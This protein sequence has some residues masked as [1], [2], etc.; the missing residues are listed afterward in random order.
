MLE[1][2]AAGERLLR[3]GYAGDTYNTAVYIRRVAVELGLDLDVGYL[4]GLGGDD[5]SAQMRA[6]W[7]EEGIADRSLTIPGRLPGLYAVTT[8]AT[9]ERRFSY[10][11]EQSAASA[12][13]AGSDWC[14]QLGADLVHLSGITLQLVAPEARGTLRDRLLELRAGGTLVSFD[15]NYRAAG[16]PSPAA[17][18]EA[19]AELAGACDIVFASDGDERLLHGPGSPAEHIGR[20]AAGTG[21]EVI[22]RSGAGGAYVSSGGAPAVHVAAVPV[23]RVVDTTGAGDAFGG[24]YLAARLAGEPPPRAAAFG[25]AVAGQVI[26]HPGA[27]T[28]QDIRLLGRVDAAI[29]AIGT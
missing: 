28:A 6:A 12:L 14:L 2:T 24:A 29:L 16:W 1:L 22:L 26:Q 5:Y 11:R 7:L 15:T 20:L 27:I 21:A 13:F 10:W 9:G 4:T 25:N 19:M 17:A 18:A 3:L 8:S 23:A